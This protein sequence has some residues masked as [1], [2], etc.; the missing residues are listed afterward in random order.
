MRKAFT[1]RLGHGA[2]VMA[3]LLLFAAAASATI[4]YEVSL[5]R[6]GE[7]QFRIGMSIPDVRG[8]VTIQMA[9]WD[10]LYQIRD[11]AH[12]VSEMRAQDAGGAALRLTRLD[13]QT[14]SIEG[15]G[16]VRV[17]YAMH[18]D[19]PGP[20]GT[21]LN[22]EHAF[23]NLA[24][25]LCYVPDRLMEDVVVRYDDV[26]QGWRI[27]VRLPRATGTG[28]ATAFAAA[29]Y[30]D[31]VDAPVEIA[32]F[33][34]VQ[35]R[36]AGRLIRA[37]IHG[38][39][40]D[41]P[42]LVSTL[43][44]IIEYQARLMGDAPFDEYLFIYHV[45]R[46]YGGG[47]MEHANSTAISVSST[48]GLANLSAHEFFHLWNVKRIRPQSLEPL[49]RTREMWTKALWFAEG[50]TNTYAAYT[51]VR[52]GLWSRMEFLADLS[53]Q[54][55]EFYSRPA[56]RWQSAEESSLVTWF[57]KY[58]LYNRPQGSISY[59]NKGQLL[60]LGL[61]IVMRDASDNRAGLDDVLRWLNQNY[62]QRGR[63]YAD[64]EGI[65]SAA[66]AVLR[67]RGVG[68]D[69]ANL[70]EFFRRYVAGTDDLPLAEWLALAGLSVR[71][72]GTRREVIELSNTSDQQMRILAGLLSGSVSG[73]QVPAAVGVGGR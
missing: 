59:Y 29:N 40:L 35:F 20:F 11:F 15:N 22:S 1:S 52:A 9:A 26:P 24:M 8:Q 12:H 31:L 16:E 44:S 28:L 48:A 32:R 63:F 67:E 58:A 64:S 27:A 13:K 42:R 3:L 41:R 36:A 66:E 7:H 72:S 71:G 17:E 18:W 65:R 37:V 57:D 6:P 33:E 30:D 47:G 10:A 55:S 2:A 49:D 14:W 51:L 21:Q 43:T 25:V 50:V 34:E 23:I 19:E 5:A 39:P 73:A 56:H 62:A 4:R 46:Q 70:A 61:D 38:D 53:E 54:I 68:G 69:K 60:G 45:G